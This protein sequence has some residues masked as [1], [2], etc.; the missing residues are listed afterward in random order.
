MF[1]DGGFIGKLILL[2]LLIFIS[3]AVSVNL[4]L[5]NLHLHLHR[6]FHRFHVGPIRHGLRRRH[7]ECSQWS[8][9]QDT[10]KKI[11]ATGGEIVV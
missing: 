8:Q 9:S 6:L 3:E 4:R 5:I 10:L 7:L 11:W 1:W 2:L